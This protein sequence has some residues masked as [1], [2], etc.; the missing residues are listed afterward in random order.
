MNQNSFNYCCFRLSVRFTFSCLSFGPLQS[1][2]YQQQILLL[3]QFMAFTHSPLHFYTLQ[4]LRILLT[5]HCADVHSF[6]SE[7]DLHFF[8]W[9]CTLVGH[10][11]IKMESLFWHSRSLRYNSTHINDRIFSSANA[12][13][14]N[15]TLIPFL[16]TRKNAWH[17]LMNLLSFSCLVLWKCLRQGFKAWKKQLAYN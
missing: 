12:C 1:L 2:F 3:M 11:S 6:S 14:V 17:Y 8:V 16:S 5:C 13:S 9:D 7:Y 15:S 10:H 4:V